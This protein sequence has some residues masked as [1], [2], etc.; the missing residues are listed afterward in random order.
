VTHT[1]R[2]FMTPKLVYVRDD[3]RPQV[4][5]HPILEMGITAVPVLD[6]EHRPVGV[7][8][9][10]DLVE[11]PRG[12]IRPMSKPALLIQA[13]ASIES[14]ARMLSEAEEHHLVVVDAG[15]H[16]VGMLSSLDVVRAF[17]HAS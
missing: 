11:N 4:A 2:D 5:L 17:L 3:T 15:G 10:R 14:A 7:I 8:S 16:A 1:V 13:T 9:L 6:G 12:D